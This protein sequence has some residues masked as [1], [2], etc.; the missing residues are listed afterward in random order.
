ML[1]ISSFFRLGATGCYRASPCVLNF[2]FK[3]GLARREGMQRL[4]SLTAVTGLMAE[5][6]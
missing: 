6:G 3:L 5:E 1:E 4:L 2:L